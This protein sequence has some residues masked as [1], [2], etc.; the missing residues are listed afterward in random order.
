MGAEHLLGGVGGEVGVKCMTSLR[1]GEWHSECKVEALV[2]FQRPS[3]VSLGKP[4][5]LTGPQEARV[6]MEPDLCLGGEGSPWSCP[7]SCLVAKTLWPVESEDQDL[8]LT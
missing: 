5:G 7:A 4:L 6:F 8:F 3:S 1:K 2:S